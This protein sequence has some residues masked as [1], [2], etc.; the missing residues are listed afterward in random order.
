MRKYS[1]K[2]ERD[3]ARKL[4]SQGYPIKEIA[5]KLNRSAAAICEWTNLIA[6]RESGFAVDKV[7]YNNNGLSPG[8]NQIKRARDLREKGHSCQDIGNELGLSGRAVARWTY[9]IAPERHYLVPTGELS[10]QEEGGIL[11]DE[12]IIER[13]QRFGLEQHL[14]DFLR[15]NWEDTELGHTWTL[16][17]DG[18][19]SQ[20]GY[21]YV[22]DIGKIDLLAKSKTN[23]DLLVVELKR[24]Q[25]SDKTVGQILRYMGW[26]KEQILEEGACVRGLIIAYEP[27]EKIRYALKCVK[28]VGLKLYH[29]DFH[30]DDLETEGE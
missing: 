30:L 27:D 3:M 21:E 6:M 22:T 15:Y 29:V 19:D 10:L 11:E 14:H 25:T 8:E 2:E 5:K 1:Q 26:I 9:D 7:S 24:D 4:R 16:A 18:D 13:A 28:D 12:E 23:N 17:I 20:S